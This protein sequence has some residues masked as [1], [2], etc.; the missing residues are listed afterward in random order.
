MT[1]DFS[2]NPPTV[3]EVTCCREWWKW[4]AF[5]CSKDY[6]EA[7]LQGSESF[8]YSCCLRLPRLL[9]QHGKA[10]LALSAKL[11]AM[12]GTVRGQSTA[13]QDG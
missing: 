7:A 8:H 10:V 6:A 11:D 4:F 12:T 13:L 9:P 2:T 5:L 3:R 1:S